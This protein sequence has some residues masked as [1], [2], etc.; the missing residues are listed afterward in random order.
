MPASNKQLLASRKL[1]AQGAK[2][3]KARE[4]PSTKRL[5]L[6][7]YP[8]LLLINL[9]GIGV[10]ANRRGNSEGY[11]IIVCYPTRILTGDQ[12]LV[13]VDV[14]L[15]AAQTLRGVCVDVLHMLNFV[16]AFVHLQDT[17][18]KPD[19]KK[20]LEKAEGKKTVVHSPSQINEPELKRHAGFIRRLFCF[21]PGIPLSRRSSEFCPSLNHAVDNIITSCNVHRL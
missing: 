8:Y 20:Q 18:N 5:Y 16:E 11:I 9:L 3:V 21:F 17:R 2:L 13:L 7:V 6:C 14:E 19:F 15:H 4:L 1:D 12:V 10:H